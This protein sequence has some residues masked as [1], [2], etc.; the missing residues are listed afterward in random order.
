MSRLLDPTICPDCR[1]ALDESAT[2]T[3]CRLRVTGPLALELWNAMVTADRLVEQLREAA[4]T[5]SDQAADPASVGHRVGGPARAADLPAYPA[6]PPRAP[7][8][9]RRLPAASVPVVLLSLGALCLLVAAVVFVAVTWSLMGLTGRT[10]VL[11]GLTGVLAGV[12][13]LLTRRTLR[14]AAETFWL[15]VA[16][17]L[18]VDLLA[19]QSAGLAGLDALDWRGTSALV[20]AALLAL[21]TAVALWVRRESIDHLYGVQAV[22]V[23]GAALLCS[24]NAWSAE[25]PAVA[26]TVAV[27][28][29]AALFALL[30]RPVPLTAYGIGALGAASWLVLLGIG[31][32]RALEETALSAW[33]GDL[34]GWPLVVAAAFGAVLTLAPGLPARA[35]PVAAGV[36]LFPLVLLARAP[37]TF[38]TPTRDRLVDCAILLVLAALTVLAPRVWS[39]GAAALAALGVLLLGLELL[40]APWEVLGYLDADGR[41]DVR[42]A[43]LAPSD[44]AASWTAVVL[45]LAVVVTATALLR[46]V[47]P[48]R[49]SAATRVVATVA[50]AV[51]ALGGLALVLE[52]EPPLWAGVLA[53]A[54]ATATAGWAAWWSRD[55]VLAGS[56]GS[57]GTAYLAVVMLY[58]A[59]AAD[60]L[61]ALTGTATFVLLAA[62]GALRD[63]VG[64]LYSAPLL[65]GL[66]ALAG[67]WALG[68]WAAVLEAGSTTITLALAVYAG[69]VGVA[70]APLTRRTPTRVTLEAM[71]AALGVLATATSADDQTSAM[72]LTILGSAICLIAVTTRDRAA[73]GWTGA[74]VLGIATVIRL[75]TDVAAPE[76]YTLP[77]AA[78]LVMVGA[79]RL[80]P[81]R[82]TEAGTETGPLPGTATGTS[83]FTVLG[84]GLTL[85][86]LPSLLLALDEP[87]SLRGALVGAAGVVVLAVGV[88]QRLAAPFLLGALTTAVLALRHLEPVADAVPRW[89]SLGGVGVALLV[90]G[91]T[92]EARRRNLESAH[93]YLTALR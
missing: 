20:G 23:G 7:R 77:A 70:A 45:A 75:A 54:L 90:V 19:A 44:N 91:V 87:V 61:T 31:W 57:A 14:V 59:L 33:W 4:V 52:L 51:L 60:V 42:F 26:T 18:T 72:T 86:L 34:R 3:A 73:L 22:A 12:A 38:E 79:W 82:E 32:G 10:L 50:P 81:H 55:D 56:V 49:R 80:R 68:G 67:A 30:R 2:C 48:F 27:P 39:W 6:P 35:R 65:A 93:R 92:W 85:A 11:L 9:A 74:V 36:A 16:G 13:V 69:L 1:G 84:S 41:A 53:A 83:S 21:G 64:A 15:V 28:L 62:A 8:R 58:A 71:A 29:L 46:Q 76:L 63:K 89:V 40:V 43:M 24:T 37:L 25:N 88:H 5:R 66:A 17:M 47:P 78:V